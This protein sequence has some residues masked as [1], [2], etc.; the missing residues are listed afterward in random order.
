MLKPIFAVA[1]MMDWTDRHCRAFHRVLSRRARLYTEMVTTG[2]VIHGPRERLLGFSDAEHPVAQALMKTATE[3]GLDVPQASGFESIPGHG[4]RAE[5]S[6]RAEEVFRYGSV[7]VHPI[8]FAT[9]MTNIPSIAEYQVRQTSG[10]VDVDVVLHGHVDLT[11]LIA[12][13][14]DSLR[15]AGLKKPAAKVTVVEAIDRHAQT[16]KIRRFVP[17]A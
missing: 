4:V 9:V 2:A 10:G 1:P 17:L 5:V 3:R 12:A 7:E 6:G 15:Q 11:A 13:T 8:V 16:G 14:E